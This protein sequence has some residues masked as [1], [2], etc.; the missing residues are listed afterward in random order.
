[1]A[2]VVDRDVAEFDCASMPVAR[3]VNPS[4]TVMVP[5]LPTVTVP[6]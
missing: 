2:A 3:S 6:A 5:S 1:V 4:P